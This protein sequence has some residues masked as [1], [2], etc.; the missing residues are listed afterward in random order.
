MTYIVTIWQYAIHPPARASFEDCY[1]PAGAWVALFRRSPEYIRTELL[2]DPGQPD[3]Y[4]TL[5]YWQS[6][7]AYLA[8]L[9]TYQ[10]EYAAL[11]AA[12]A[13]LLTHEEHLGLFEGTASQA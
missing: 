8:F 2:R 13:R 12:C 11:D 1:G 7:G 4:L 10:A 3:R 6:H 5:D 9:D